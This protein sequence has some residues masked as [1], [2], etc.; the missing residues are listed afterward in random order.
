MVPPLDSTTHVSIHSGLKQPF[1]EYVCEGG[2]LEITLVFSVQYVPVLMVVHVVGNAHTCRC[3]DRCD[4][5]I[6]VIRTEQHLINGFTD[7]VRR[8]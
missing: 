4:V 6:P 8:V 1:R 2:Y 3:M 5:I 7:P